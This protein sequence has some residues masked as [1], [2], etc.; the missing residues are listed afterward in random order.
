MVGGAKGKREE[1]TE[2]QAKNETRALRANSATLGSI[3]FSLYLP[4]FP[5]IQGSGLSSYYWGVFL[6]LFL[7]SLLF[8]SPVALLVVSSFHLPLWAIFS[9]LLHPQL[10]LDTFFCIVTWGCNMQGWISLASFYSCLC[11]S[12]LTMQRN[13]W[14]KDYELYGE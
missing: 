6:C 2:K 13:V 11:H 4:T 1:T 10:F 7:C 14:R 3:S 12:H 9:C 5:R 8:L